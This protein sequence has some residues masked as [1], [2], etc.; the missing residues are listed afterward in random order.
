MKPR[1]TVVIAYTFAMLGIIGLTIHCMEYRAAHE[2]NSGITWSQFS[3]APTCTRK[4]DELVPDKSI[5]TITQIRP[6]LLKSIQ[7]SSVI[8]ATLVL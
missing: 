7:S 8:S 6:A 1:P 2:R 5:I 3:Q 4:L